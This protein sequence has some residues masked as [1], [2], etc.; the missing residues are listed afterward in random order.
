M[1]D[2][3]LWFSVKLFKHVLYN[4]EN[5]KCYI[6]LIYGLFN[7]CFIWFLITIGRVSFDHVILYI[8]LSPSFTFSFIF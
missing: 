7:E 3:E 8:I 5:Y 4:N 1:Y 6:V 2:Q